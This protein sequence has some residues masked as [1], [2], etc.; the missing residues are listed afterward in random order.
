MRQLANF[1]G[2]H[3]AVTVRDITS[4]SGLVLKLAYRL[5][6]NKPS[7][8][9]INGWKD[10]LTGLILIVWL[11]SKLRPIKSWKSTFGMFIEGYKK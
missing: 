2:E 9:K 1:G 10:I 8:W 7:G 4:M 5:D 6:M 3:K 11:R